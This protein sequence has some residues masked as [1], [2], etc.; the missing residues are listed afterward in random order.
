MEARNRSIKDWYGMVEQGQVKLPRFQHFEAW[1]RH[2]ITSLFNTI[3]HDL[4][5]GI[6]LVLEVGDQEQFVS[7][8]LNT[9][10]KTG[11]RVHEQL[12]DGQQMVAMKT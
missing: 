4:P 2:R 3:I 6:T 9:A 11:L 7:R 10:P 1:D 8:Y 5:L 12:L